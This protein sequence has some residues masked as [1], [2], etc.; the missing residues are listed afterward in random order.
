MS[1]P[2]KESVEIENEDPVRSNA[3]YVKRQWT[4]DL[5]YRQQVDCYWRLHDRTNSTLLIKVLYR[6]Y[7]FLLEG[8]SKV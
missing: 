8:V 4:Q 6:R 2:R 3:Q 7:G 5:V 1:F